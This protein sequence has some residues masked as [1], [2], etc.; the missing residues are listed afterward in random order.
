MGLYLA[1]S[2]SNFLGYVRDS[3]D[4]PEHP[5]AWAATPFSPEKCVD[6][7]LAWAREC[8]GMK[9]ACDLYVSRVVN[10]CLASQDRLA[11]CQTLGETGST[12]RFGLR[13]N[14]LAPARMSR[15]AKRGRPPLRLSSVIPSLNHCTLRI[16]SH[17]MMAH[18]QALRASTRDRWP[19]YQP[20]AER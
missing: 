5:P 15:R 1:F 2:Y 6:S 18:P 13:R 7:A 3:L 9:T 16:T 17:N 12:T 4:S 19:N 14:K 11:Y 8:K 10:E 20:A